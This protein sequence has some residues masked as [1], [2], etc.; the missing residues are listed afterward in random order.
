MAHYRIFIPN[1]NGK[2]ATNLANVGL[3]SLVRDNDW[4]PD[5]QQAK[6]PNGITGQIISWQ[7]PTTQPTDYPRFDYDPKLDTAVEAAPDPIRNLPMGRCYLLLENERPVTPSDIARKPADDLADLLPTGDDT[8]IL[9]MS[10]LHDFARMTRFGG[11]LRTLG[12]GHRWAHPNPSTLPAT[13]K[14]NDSGVWGPQVRPQFKSIY[15]RMVWG[16]NTCRS[17]IN[18]ERIRKVPT[19][20]LTDA[21][22]ESL[23]DYP[24]KPLNDELAAG[25]VSEILSLNYRLDLWIA[26]QLGL[27]TPDNLWSSITACCDLQEIQTMLSDVQKKIAATT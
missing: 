12:D 16:L 4:Q 1:A 10:K 6:G 18:D 22:H 21:D 19:D 26:G 13:F 3:G 9:R 24:P 23:R 8:E 11:Y 15:E 25:F 5:G 17:A 14:H 20:Q 2:A 7:P 27:F